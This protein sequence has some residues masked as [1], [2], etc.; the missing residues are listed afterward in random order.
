MQSCCVLAKQKLGNIAIP[1]TVC[2]C[3]AY[4]LYVIGNASVVKVSVMQ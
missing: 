1:M 3:V 4:I 2:D